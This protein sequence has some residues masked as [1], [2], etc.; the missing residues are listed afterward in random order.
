MKESIAGARRAILV[1]LAWGAAWMPAGALAARQITG[2]V[3]PE[4]IAGPLYAGFFCGALFSV[5]AGIATGRRRLAELSPV[6]AAGMGAV[7]VPFLGVLPLLI[8]EA[9]ADFSWLL[10]VAGV[11]VTTLL[12]AV[13]AVLSV[14]LARRARHSAGAHATQEGG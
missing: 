4:H 12:S 5:V 3:D 2:G 9:S 8:G 7:G 14:M 10:Y 13:S 1:G 11:G 6:H